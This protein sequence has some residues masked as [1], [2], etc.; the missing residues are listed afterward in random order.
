MPANRHVSQN[1]TGR[2]SATGTDWEQM[3][4]Q[5]P[6]GPRRKRMVMSLRGDEADLYLEHNH[7]LVKALTRSVR[8]GAPRDLEDAAAFAW[9]QFYRNQLEWKGWL[10]RTAQREAWRLNA[11][12][13][14]DARIVVDLEERRPGQAREPADPRDRLNSSSLPPWTRSSSCPKG[15]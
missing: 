1:R 7:A 14:R 11:L 15:C 4:M 6:P 5:L 12:R 9:I 13:R 8:G 2:S 3:R 10:F